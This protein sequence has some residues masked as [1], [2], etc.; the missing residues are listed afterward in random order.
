MISDK[1]A[2]IRRLKPSDSDSVF[3]LYETV[4]KRTA[5][6]FVSDRQKAEFAEILAV[7]DRSASVGAWAGD[8][9]VAYSLSSPE[10]RPVY[11][12][13]AFIR[14]IQQRGEPIWTGKGTI[15]DPE[16]EG[17]MLMPR[18]L[19]ERHSIMAASGGLH[20]A[21]LIATDNMS[22][23]AG[24]MR[25]GAW[26]VGLENDAYCLNFVCY[27]GNMRSDTFRGDAYILPVQAMDQLASRF[28]AGWVATAYKSNG[29]T[30]KRE[31]VLSAIVHAGT[32]KR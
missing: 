3:R 31:F 24:A 2:I 32:D 26:V 21:G 17:R 27:F 6:G 30:G 18:L 15:V 25:A 7:P 19:K 20:S 8:R 13:S 5:Y 22:S 29:R 23:L 10:T 14:S 12:N 28:A 9:L 16:F 1:K 4:S 11:P